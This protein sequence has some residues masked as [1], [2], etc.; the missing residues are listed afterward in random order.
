LRHVVSYKFTGISG[1][2]AASTI[3]V[4][5]EAANGYFYRTILSTVSDYGLDGRGSIPDW[6]RGFFF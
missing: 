3:T 5:M 2:L 6:G 4:I 1:V